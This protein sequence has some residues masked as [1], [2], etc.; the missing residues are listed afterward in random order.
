M[1]VN[2]QLKLPLYF[3]TCYMYPHQFPFNFSHLVHC[4]CLY[5]PSVANWH[6]LMSAVYP[7][8]PLTLTLIPGCSNNIRTSRSFWP[9]CLITFWCFHFLHWNVNLPWTAKMRGVFPFAYCAFMLVHGKANSSWALPSRPE[10]NNVNF[11]VNFLSC[12]VVL[13]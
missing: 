4:K 1:K 10:N 6:A 7:S 5:L 13:K 2:K 12:H 9:N 8:K 3:I 11:I